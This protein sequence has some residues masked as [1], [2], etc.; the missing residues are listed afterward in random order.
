MSK[1]ENYC[2][3]YKMLALYSAAK[4]LLD[5]TIRINNIAFGQTNTYSKLLGDFNAVDHCC[6]VLLE[7]IQCACQRLGVFMCDLN[8]WT[9]YSIYLSIVMITHFF[10]LNC[11]D[12]K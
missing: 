5:S 3:G 9:K 6:I 7:V 8:P 1:T 12:L 2:S 4:Y 11:C 10:A